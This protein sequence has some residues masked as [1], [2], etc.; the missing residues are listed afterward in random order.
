L[1][2]KKD[3]RKE[4]QIQAMKAAWEAAEPGRAAKAK[5]LRQLFLQKHGTSAVKPGCNASSSLTGLVEEEGEEDTSA[6]LQRH[7]RSQH[8]QS[9]TLGDRQSSQSLLVPN[10][11]SA[12]QQRLPKAIPVS[13]FKTRQPI[14][15]FDFSRF[16]RK[17]PVGVQP[18]LL[19]ENEIHRREA[20]R[21][22]EMEQFHMVRQA[23]LK[24]REQDKQERE[25]ARMIQ[26]ETAEE[27]QVGF[28]LLLVL[29]ACLSVCLYLDALCASRGLLMKP[30]IESTG[31][32]KHIA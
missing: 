27:M 2:V 7:R 5:I 21:Q 8:Q 30:E 25:K 26:L 3:T 20:K 13:P 24:A 6:P 15:E 1:D 22:E 16:V 11:K 29:P 4:E 17:C 23:V 12:A 28:W 10:Q 32:E 14:V 9:R 19:D 31:F 18:V